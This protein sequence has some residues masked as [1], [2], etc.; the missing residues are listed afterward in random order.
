MNTTRYD[1]RRYAVVRASVWTSSCRI[2]A[3]RSRSS[4]VVC[5]GS[6][7]RGRGSRIVMACPPSS[8]TGRSYGAE[9]RQEAFAA[10]DGHRDPAVEVDVVEPE[11]AMLERLAA[12]GG[13]A[14]ADVDVAELA[15]DAQ[16]GVVADPRRRVR[17]ACAERLEGEG[18]HGGPHLGPDPGALVAHAEPG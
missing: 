2:A 7:C 17:G 13:R 3:A 12:W 8:T 15:R 6:P 18:E 9:R 14:R 10:G 16:R 5:K 1:R 11:Y 4:C